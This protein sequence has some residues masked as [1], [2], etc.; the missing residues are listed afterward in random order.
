MA[1]FTISGISYA[2]GSGAR[3]VLVSYLYPLSSTAY[4]RRDAQ[5][6]IL[7]PIVITSIEFVRNVKVFY[8]TRNSYFPFYNGKYYEEDLCDEATAKILAI[9]YWEQQKEWT[10][11]QIQSCSQ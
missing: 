4:L 9:T 1:T 8:P 5:Q 6:G 10:L 2:C 7:T 3:Q 11:R